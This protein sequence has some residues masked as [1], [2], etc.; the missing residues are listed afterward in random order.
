MILIR[1][2]LKIAVS[3]A[4]A[5]VAYVETTKLKSRVDSLYHELSQNQ[6][7]YS[8]TI[9]GHLIRQ[10]H[11]LERAQNN[12]VNKLRKFKQLIFQYFKLFK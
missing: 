10:I 6:N 4:I 7:H 11:N 1:A 2:G 9:Q 12:I 8:S 5:T 3:V